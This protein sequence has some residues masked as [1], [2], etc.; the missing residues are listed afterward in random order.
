MSNTKTSDEYSYFDG[1]VNANCL[2]TAKRKAQVAVDGKQITDA[3]LRTLIYTACRE[4]VRELEVA[5]IVER[6]I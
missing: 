3:S 4:Y 6:K 1:K 5:G 2:R